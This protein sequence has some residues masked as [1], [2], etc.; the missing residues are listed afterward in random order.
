MTVQT[1]ILMNQVNRALKGDLDSAKFVRDT[2]GEFIWS[3][4]NRKE[5]KKE[6]E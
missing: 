3:R 2:S 6:K 1:G 4:G 5:N